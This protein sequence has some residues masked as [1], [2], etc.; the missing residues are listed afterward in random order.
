MY[1][2]VPPTII[3][4]KM[5][6]SYATVAYHIRKI[7]RITGLNPRTVGGLQKLYDTYVKEGENERTR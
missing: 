7:I 5:F 4:D 1:K 3:A 6:V 2:G